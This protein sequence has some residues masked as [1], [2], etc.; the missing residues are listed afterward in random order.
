[1]KSQGKPFIKYKGECV[2]VFVPIIIFKKDESDYFTAACLPSDIY[3]AGYTIEEAES[4]INEHIELFLEETTR[5]GTLQECL[6][7]L[8]WKFKTKDIAVINPPKNTLSVK[9]F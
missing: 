8:G 4:A 5:K 7:D 2:T 9:F 1:M 3:S 6:I